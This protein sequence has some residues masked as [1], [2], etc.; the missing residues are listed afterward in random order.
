MESL[1]FISSPSIRL[2]SH[3]PDGGD[4]GDSDDE[5]S[6]CAFIVPE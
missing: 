6:N 4:G 5:E 1:L 3:L 2:D